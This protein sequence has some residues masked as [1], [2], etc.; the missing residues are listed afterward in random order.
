MLQ[1][2]KNNQYKEYT[3]QT[4]NK[5]IN[6][7]LVQTKHAATKMAELHKLDDLQ[8]TPSPPASLPSPI[9]SWIPP[10]LMCSAAHHVRYR[11]IRW[12]TRKPYCP[13]F[14]SSTAAVP[15]LVGGGS[16]YR[17]HDVKFS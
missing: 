2:N 4:M 3:N 16:N 10:P 8:D 14:S 17:Q 12:R 15:W 7:Y 9:P 13:N 5:H 11:V 6:I 1:T